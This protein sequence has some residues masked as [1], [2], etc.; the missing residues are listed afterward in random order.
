[1]WDSSLKG[2]VMSQTPPSS[3]ACIITYTNIVAYIIIYII[4]NS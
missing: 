1:L 2:E 3:I 4:V